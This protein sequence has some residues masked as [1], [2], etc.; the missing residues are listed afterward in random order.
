MV[1]Q[2]LSL[3]AGI[4]STTLA[5]MA[6][7]GEIEPPYCAIFADTQ[8][9]PAEVYAHLGRLEKLLPF[10]VYRVT[11][12]DIR[13]TIATDSYDPIPWHVENGLGRRQCTHQF[14]LRPI[15]AKVRE[16]LG[17]KRPRAGAA[18]MWLGISR[19]EAHR[20]K[21]ATVQYIENRWPL[22]ERGMTRA[23]CRAWLDQ[24]G[25][26]APRSACC[27]CPLLSN[28]DWRHRR[29]QPEWNDT[30]AW[31]YKLAA[32]GEY[33]HHSLRPLD[34]ADLGFDDRQMDLFGNEC[35]GGCGV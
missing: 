8:W 12:G 7:R 5:L 19:D 15:K 1:L 3:G 33:M 22:I 32:R 4:Q 17:I 35:A 6:A 2:V 13:A 9:E 23:D 29:T 30:V 16:L 24:H 25:V 26:S 18:E 31:S 20:M 21:P 28:E 34:Q 14:K 27:G 10:P 11:A